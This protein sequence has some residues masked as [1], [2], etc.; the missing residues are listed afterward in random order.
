MTESSTPSTA[1]RALRVTLILGVPLA[2]LVGAAWFA[3]HSAARVWPSPDTPALESL[4]AVMPGCGEGEDLLYALLRAGEAPGPEVM[5]VDVD[6]PEAAV[7][8]FEDT[9]D[10]ALHH[11]LDDL[12]ACGGLRL[13]TGRGTRVGTDRLQEVAEQRIARAESW[14]QQGALEASATDLAAVLRLAAILELGGGDLVLTGAGVAVGVA[15]IQAIERFLDA[16]PEASESTLE[17]LAD[18]LNG[19]VAL[20]AGVPYAMV[21]ECRERENH[22]RNL[23][24]IPAPAMMLEP[25]GVPLWAGWAAAWL[26]GA[27]VYDAPHT[28]AMHR[29]RCALRLDRVRAGGLASEAELGPVLWNPGQ[30]ALGSMLDN[31]LGRI[32]LTEDDLAVRADSVIEAERGLRSRRVLLATRVALERGSLAHD[33]LL[34]SHLELLVPE[35]LPEIPVDPVDGESINWVRSHGE[36]FTTR[37]VAVT[38]GKLQRLFTKVPER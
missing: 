36:V 38:G 18:A 1:L 16:H 12:L 6:Q 23:A 4:P 21:R 3:A 29:H 14:S 7:Q 19:Q 28:L 24:A 25:A 13:T 31:P 26:P 37:E 5:P 11:A 20:P 32:A 15:A 35:F 2:V 9:R 34:P 30:L 33:G 17:V 10:Q 27:T 8:G 22:L